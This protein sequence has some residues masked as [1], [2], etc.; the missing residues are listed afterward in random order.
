M[1]GQQVEQAALFYEFRFEERV[2]EGHL[3]RR[4]DA[5]LDLGF[6]REP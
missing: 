1:M 5:I 4:V 2:P 3:L 6:V